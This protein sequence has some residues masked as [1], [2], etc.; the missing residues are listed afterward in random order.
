[1]PSAEE[2]LSADEFLDAKEAPSADEFL[3]ADDFLDAGA[4]RALPA[5]VKAN[6]SAGAGRGSR[7]GPTAEEMADYR[8]SKRAAAYADRQRKADRK[9][10]A[11]LKDAGLSDEAT[12]LSALRAQTDAPAKQSLLDQ[13]NP[14]TEPPQSFRE[15]NDQQRAVERNIEA[16]KA[17][18]RTTSSVQAADYDT[19]IPLETDTSLLGRIKSGAAGGKAAA[20]KQLSNLA[21]LGAK[22]IGADDLADLS[23]QSA[24][25]WGATKRGAEGLNEDSVVTQ[26]AAGL[27]GMLPLLVGSATGIAAMAT[28]MGADATAEALDAGQEAPDAVARGIAFGLANALS[29][30]VRIPAIEAGFAKLAAKAPASE[31]G[32]VMADALVRNVGAM[33]AQTI[34]TDLYDKF[35][36]GGLR[37]DMAPGEM[38]DHVIQTVKVAALTTAA[39]PGV[40]L[41][42]RAGARGVK[43]AMDVGT[44]GPEAVGLAEAIRG[45]TAGGFARRGPGGTEAEALRNLSGEIVPEAG[46]LQRV[47]NRVAPGEATLMPDGSFAQEVAPIDR[48]AYLV[49]PRRMAPE[50]SADTMP[51]DRVLTPDELAA[52][53]ADG[54]ADRAATAQA[55]SIAER[56]RAIRPMRERPQAEPAP[57]EPAARP[58]AAPARTL[59]EQPAEAPPADVSGRAQT[60]NAPA[61]PAAEL[62][63]LAS[64]MRPGP[65]RDAL[66]ERAQ[67]EPSAVPAAEPSATSAQTGSAPDAPSPLPNAPLPQA[68][69]RVIEE[70]LQSEG[71]TQTRYMGNKREFFGANAAFVAKN[72]APLMREATTLFD[73][74]AGGGTYGL[75]VALSG[76]MPNVKR[77]VVNEVDPV[78]AERFRLAA[79]GGS[80]IIDPWT[81]DPKLVELAGALRS[82]IGASSTPASYF[83]SSYVG[84]KESS[85]HGA[86]ARRLARA[87]GEL[88]GA[89]AVAVLA[90]RDVMFSGRTATWERLMANA[91]ADGERIRALVQR[92]RDRG[93]AVDLTSHDALG[94]DAVDMVRENGGRAVVLLDPPYH[95]TTEG[96]YSAG[97][98]SYDFKSDA[99][100]GENLRAAHEMG[101]GNVVL[102]NNKDTQEVRT[103]FRQAFG[104]SM[105]QR[106]WK[107]ANGQQ[108][109]F[110]VYDGRRTDHDAGAHGA[111]ARATEGSSVGQ[112]RSDGAVLGRPAV[113][114]P[115][116]VDGRAVRSAESDGRQP[117]PGAEARRAVEPTGESSERAVEAQPPKQS[118]AA[119]PAPERAS[120]PEALIAARKRESV[121]R[122]IREC[123]GA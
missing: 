118:R 30:K 71:R 41:S 75:T 70:A 48:T 84:A 44:H 65:L 22:A 95:R 61:M 108:E 45:D 117:V 2:F 26:T 79:D 106:V 3:S 101:H 93:I 116:E 88:S 60:M 39:L 66:T 120:R 49:P 98:K 86:E 47:P 103:G 29:M 115:G 53:A 100:L 62:S 42:A 59:V 7:G 89:S 123:L 11:D 33:G 25:Y 50:I 35:A 5:G 15:A 105:L 87:H 91:A 24:T 16:L 64:T 90:L 111:D 40:P 114:G 28:G 110:G 19:R 31:L 83:L 58:Q 46:G 92:A 43:R 76:A 54:Q 57:V 14:Y 18:P 37:K 17:Q 52:H 9:R 8:A 27:V 20:G 51:A 12:P 72:V 55:D 63:R 82:R 121:L 21:R 113:G 13:P 69:T 23:R 67:R 97:G 122:S 78:R 107:R 96:T 94:A 85:A 112:A 10:E 109:Y 74:Y 6:E 56:M 32:N 1:M 102:Y 80:K 4:Q 99:F 36:P 68:T 73:M 104:G 38:L 81:T 34:A 77:V 119:E